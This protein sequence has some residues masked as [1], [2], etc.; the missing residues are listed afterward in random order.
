MKHL[1][2]ALG[3]WL[4]ASVAGAQTF[5]NAANG[6]DMTGG[7]ALTSIATTPSINVAST[8]HLVVGV[9]WAVFNGLADPVVTD[10]A[11]NTFTPSSCARVETTMNTGNWL[12]I[13]YAQNTTGNANDIVTASWSGGTTVWFASIVVLQHTGVA[14]SSSLDTCS[15]TG[16]ESTPTCTSAS[17]TTTTA[18]QVIVT[19]AQQN[20]IGWAWSA[21]TGNTLRQQDG[22]NVLGAQTQVVTGIQTT[23][24]EFMTSAGTGIDCAVVV[25]TFKAAGTSISYVNASVGSDLTGTPTT[26]LDLSPMNLASGNHVMVGVRWAV[27]SAGDPSVSDTAGNNYIPVGSP[28]G[29]FT[30]V[31]RMMAFYAQNTAANPSN[32]IRVTWPVTATFMVGAAMQH[33]GVS[34][35]TGVNACAT[36]MGMTPTITSGSYTTT[37]ANTVIGSF[38]SQENVNQTWT[39]GGAAVLRI[40]DDDEVFG[41]QSRIVSAIQTGATESMVSP[42][43]GDVANIITIAFAEG[44]SSGGGGGG[45]THKRRMLLGVK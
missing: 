11:G 37:A 22:S 25:T 10:T 17:Y 18:N 2:C 20:D 3:I 4:T 31:V 9:R 42:G 1:L 14:L 21:G 45:G 23:Q 41:A 43:S 16:S 27:G 34:G 33:S 6:S 39:A 8:N 24:T 12:K 28:C 30:N 29:P 13:Y 26:T 44:A 38:A 7:G 15:T 19:F 40:Q 35:T 32:V 5:V 36:G